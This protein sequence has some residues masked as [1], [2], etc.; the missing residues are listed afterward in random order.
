MKVTR[1]LLVGFVGLLLIPGCAGGGNGNGGGGGGTVTA[2]NPVPVL[3]SLTP[4]AALLNQPEFTLTARGSD[5]VSGAKMVFRGSELDT[6]WVSATELTALVTEDLTAPAAL[7]SPQLA[8]QVRVRNPTPGGGDSQSVNFQLKKT[9]VFGTPQILAGGADAYWN[10]LACKDESLYAWYQDTDPANYEATQT[11][12]YIVRSDDLGE[13]WN[14]AVKFNLAGAPSY[15]C[16]AAFSD[17]SVSVVWTAQAGEKLIF[18]RSTD[19]G[20]TWPAGKNLIPA[21]DGDFIFLNYDHDSWPDILITE[22]GTIHVVTWRFNGE[23]FWEGGYYFR[24]TDHGAHWS[25]NQYGFN[26]TAIRLAA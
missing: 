2:D 10:G 5:F 18:K 7:D 20:A 9:P 25:E 16:A 19:N 22:N 15:P 8:V 1:F 3:N 26:A 21:I 6:T 23:G 14:N 4:G 13:N 24:S 11:G 17:N 12:A